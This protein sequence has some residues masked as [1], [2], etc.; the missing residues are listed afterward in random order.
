MGEKERLFE[1]I[2]KYFRDNYYTLMEIE[3]TKGQYAVFENGKGIGELM[4]GYDSQDHISDVYYAENGFYHDITSINDIVEIIGDEYVADVPGDEAFDI[5]TERALEEER[6]VFD[7]DE[8]VAGAAE[9]VPI[10]IETDSHRKYEEFME[11][12]GGIGYELTPLDDGR[13]YIARYEGRNVGAF[14]E[15]ENGMITELTLGDYQSKG[16]HSMDLVL[17]DYNLAARDIAEEIAKIN[18]AKA[19]FISNYPDGFGIQDNDGHT[20]LLSNKEL[21]AYIDEH[22]I[23]DISV[24]G[25]EERVAYALVNDLDR[26]LSQPVKGLEEIDKFRK[27]I[28][29]LNKSNKKERDMEGKEFEDFKKELADAGVTV[30]MLDDGKTYTANMDGK[31]LAA[32][33]NLDGAMLER[34]TVGEHREDGVSF[35]EKVLKDIKEM[36]VEVARDKTQ[37]EEFAAR[38]RERNTVHIDKNMTEKEMAESVVNYINKG[39][40]VTEKQAEWIESF[41]KKEK[42]PSKVIKGEIDELDNERDSLLN[43]INAKEAE[44]EKLSTQL[45]H[46]IAIAKMND[47]PEEDVKSMTAIANNI[48]NNNRLINSERIRLAEVEKEILQKE[49][50]YKESLKGERKDALKGLFAKAQDTLKQGV[51]LGLSTMTKMKEAMERVNLKVIDNRETREKVS[52]YKD[53]SKQINEINIDYCRKM[54]IM[55]N[56]YSLNREDLED[57]EKTFTR[58]AELRGAIKDV[59]L[60][61]TGREAAHEVKLTDREKAELTELRS[62]IQK[63]KLDMESLNTSYD[64]IIAPKLEEI[65]DFGKAV[66]ERGRDTGDIFSA[67]LNRIHAENADRASNLKESSEKILSGN[68]KKEAK[69]TGGDAR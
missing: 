66:E 37:R 50:T 47:C 62:L 53:L 54:E 7:D 69:T 52:A 51:H 44:N 12:L 38:E 22:G 42:M 4:A 39:G 30:T 31:E 33:R 59:G 16:T 2:Q 58:R 24:Q 34:L 46:Q 17:D 65:K 55:K 10:D 25:F 13:A 64:R 28:N 40:R 48:R 19:E 6:A 29:E 57:L 35:K 1:E 11:K 63:N 21:E 67:R 60:L 43:E 15:A 9:E 23:E 18:D 56:E 49:S 20:K 27:D 68:D 26:E 3:G 41:D 45:G 5:A 32:F 61:L 36:A 14:M 8:P